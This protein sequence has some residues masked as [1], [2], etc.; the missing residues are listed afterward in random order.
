[1]MMDRKLGWHSSSS[2]R[3]SKGSITLQ[4]KMVESQR[5][6]QQQQQQQPP[7]HQ[8]APDLTDFMNDMFF[9]TVNTSSNEK[10]SYN[11]T[12]SHHLDN[13]EEES[14]FDDSV[15]SNSS[16]LTQEW[17]EEAR[18]MMAMSPSRADSHSP[19]RL[20]GSPR[21]GAVPGRNPAGPV[22]D[23]RDPLSRSA[24]RHRPV[25][26]FSGE[27]LTKSAKHTRNKSE[28]LDNSTPNSPVDSS[29]ASQVQ[30]WLNSILN[31]SNL[32]D[33]PSEPTSPRE[34]NGSNP[35]LFDPTAQTLPPRQPINRKSRFQNSQPPPVS[36]P[37]GIPVTSRRT[38]KPAPVP[39]TD[40]LL[41]PPKNLVESAHRRS[42]SSSTCSKPEN[43]PLSPANNLVDSAR[44]RPTCSTEKVAPKLNADDSRKEEGEEELSLN[45]F[46]KEQRIKIDK[47]LFGEINSKAKIILSGPSN[48]TSS[49]VAAI[50][51]AWLL[52]NRLMNNKGKGDR[53]GYCVVPVMNIRR[54]KMWKQRQAAWLFHHV[55][56]DATSLLFADEV[57]LE[58][59]VMEGKLNVLVVRQ[60]ILQP[61]HEVGSQCTILTDNYCEDAYDLLQTS[62]LKKL[63]LAGIL[64]DTR[65]LNGMTKSSMTRDAEA[66]QLLLVGSAP[67]Y[68]NTL[69]DQ[70]MQDQKQNSFFE[71]LRCNYGKPPTES[72]LD[73][74]AQMDHRGTGRKSTSVS[75]DEVMKQ[76][77]DKSSN[78][79]RN[80]K[81]SK[82]TPKSAK[83]NT[84]T[85][86]KAAPEKTTPEQSGGKNNFFGLAKWFGF[87][88]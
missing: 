84:A 62:V 61:S 41:S 52:E 70:L 21:F 43:Q 46:L 17:L 14:S 23:R 51:Y 6:K 1:M 65:N 18:R 10:K 39:D 19:S 83:P 3:E 58:S 34:S 87:G 64:L 35:S 28:S 16:R 27:I 54:E 88:K 55:G 80:A 77:S 24:R 82:D 26:S 85:A 20:S 76:S 81:T 25:E 8:H 15:R 74:G 86:P 22:F 32:P 57:D 38:F 75:P 40:Q 33:S 7:K 9:G 73:S 47:I 45:R 31:P 11:L 30:R 49:M 66:V 67:N 29:P 72:G 37:Q 79:A 68:R 13:E 44:R 50:C 78:N 42:I 63:L 53:E 71:A 2:S 48:S 36:S 4:K 12:G 60:D 56:L 5:T 59:L 69:F